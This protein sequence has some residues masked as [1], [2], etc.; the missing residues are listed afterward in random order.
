LIDL[1]VSKLIE[2]DIEW[3]DYV[4]ISGMYIQKESVNSIIQ[5]V[6]KYNKKIVAGGPLFTQEYENYS[7]I[8]HFILNEAEITFPIFLEQL[9]KGI[10][11][12]RVFKT[13]EYAD[14]SK[15]PVP[16]YHLLKKNKYAL[17]NIQISRG[18][19]FSCDFCEITALLGHKVRMKTNH[20]ILKELEVLYKLNWRGQ[21][22]VVDDNFIGNKK[23]VKTE[24]LPALI[25][26]MKEHKYPFLF[27][28]QTS[29]NLA[30]DEA[31]L[32]LMVEAG[33]NSTFIG[34]ETTDE[35]SLHDC[36]KKQNENRD[37][38]TN[39][40]QIQQAGIQV[41]A[42]FIVGF[43]NDSASVFQRQVDFIQDSGIVSAMVGLLN[44]PKNTQL[45]KRMEDENRLTIEATG[46]NTDYTMNFT[47]KMDTSE[48]LNGYKYIIYNI[49][50]VKPYYKRIRNYFRNYTMSQNKQTQF[51][52][53]FIVA[54]LMSILI[55][56][57]LNNG[58]RE[59]WRFFLWTLFN[60]PSLFVDAIAFTIY[61]Y[62]FRTIYG[63]KKRDITQ[64]F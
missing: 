38:L 32:Q 14:L 6:K 36:Q 29:I 19:P 25:L 50:S 46:S 35:N 47:P 7:Q 62:H 39:V 51:E 27:N 58:R 56:G 55:I 57:I 60:N 23:V 4:F 42:G 8:D 1:N 26:W 9:E 10:T 49:Y 59:Y 17:M 43:D 16:D 44:A 61:G 54:F 33:F 41:S 34:I 5:K 64:R 3:S 37:I 31:L 2:K 12:D 15:T 20:Q 28:A 13:K 53:S 18:C 11:P 63:L 45:Y 24:L 40:K 52:F 22:A 48:L 21:V 30:D